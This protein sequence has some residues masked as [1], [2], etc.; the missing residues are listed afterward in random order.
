MAAALH[1]L[2]GSFEARFFGKKKRRCQKLARRPRW[3]ELFFIEEGTKIHEA[4]HLS[5]LA[6]LARHGQTGKS[7][8][9]ENLQQFRN[10]RGLGNHHGT[11]ERNGNL[12]DGQV[13]QIKH[14]IDHAA[15]FGGKILGG[16]LHDKAKFITIAKEIAR[17][18]AA[19]RPAQETRRENFHQ[20]DEW[21]ENDVK[22][23]ERKG[24]RHA[25]PVRIEAK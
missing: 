7:A 12:A 20:P 22:Q 19:S 10:R 25:E 3:I 15:L 14:A 2:Q 8:L 5:P 9:A 23:P 6:S 1:A 13:L 4:H 17:K 18:P 24:H 21:L 16:F 11:A